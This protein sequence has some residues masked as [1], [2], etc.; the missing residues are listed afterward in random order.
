MQL[1]KKL[2]QEYGKEFSDELFLSLEPPKETKFRN[3]LMLTLNGN[4]IKHEFICSTEVIKG[5]IVALF[6]VFPDGG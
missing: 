4:I 1:L 2:S 3:D 5:D 6:P